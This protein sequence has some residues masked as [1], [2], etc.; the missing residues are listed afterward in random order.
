VVYLFF[1]N[2]R[3]TALIISAFLLVACSSTPISIQLQPEL[4]TKQPTELLT[5]QT[6]WQIAS[7]D[8]RVAQY[9]IE[10]T[11]GE[12]V[13]TLVNE[14]QS[15][16]LIIENALQ[17][18]WHQSG[19]KLNDLSTNRINIQVIELLAKVKQKTFAHTIDSNIVINI[20]LQTNDKVF[21]KTF[22]SHAA[23][24]APFTANINKTGQQLN[25]QLSQLLNEIIKDP[26]LNVKLQQL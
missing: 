19:L 14:A 20:Q 22:T 18:K 21:N 17:Q 9:L 24:E 26:E 16:R 10:V 12:G 25:I 15:S 4:S 5:S 7:Q 13:A 2:I 8:Y 11:K 1:K 6:S 3:Q 23:Q